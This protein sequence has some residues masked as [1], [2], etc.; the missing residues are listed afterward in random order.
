MYIILWHGAL[1]TKATFDAEV[2]PFSS[3]PPAVDPFAHQEILPNLLR[4]FPLW[5]SY[6]QRYLA[7]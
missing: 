7:S 4:I 6:C 5:P 1:I 3:S 2:L